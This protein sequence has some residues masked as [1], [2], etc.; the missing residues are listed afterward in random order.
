ME[1][2]VTSF[3]EWQIVAICGKFVMK[4]LGQVTKTFDALEKA[5]KIFIAIDLQSTTY[6]DSSAITFLV[7][8]FRRVKQKNGNIVFFGANEDI[9]EV[10]N[11]VGLDGIFHFYKTRSQFEQAVTPHLS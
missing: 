1:I 8:V 10:I 7:S 3:Q 4:S 9:M 6:L 11:I 2:L 5:E